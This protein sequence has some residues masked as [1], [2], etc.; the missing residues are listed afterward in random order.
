MASYM[1]Q[2]SNTQNSFLHMDSSPKNTC[3]MGQPI[4]KPNRCILC[5]KE[6]QTNKHI[7]LKCDFTKRCWY[8]IT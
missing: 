1:G 5:K 3:N 2:A 8:R 4:E 7:F 6:S